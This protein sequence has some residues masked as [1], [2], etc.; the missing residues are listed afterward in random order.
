MERDWNLL[1]VTVSERGG[2]HLFGFFGAACRR[3]G[4]D[5]RFWWEVESFRHT[6]RRYCLRGA[7]IG[8]GVRE[9]FRKRGW[10]F[11]H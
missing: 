11:R 1:S 3:D 7:T 5:R 4:E 8:E 2:M 10:I 6:R 9:L